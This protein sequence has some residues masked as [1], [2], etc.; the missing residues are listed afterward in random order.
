MVEGE[1]LLQLSYLKDYWEKD[2][3]M[4]EEIVRLINKISKQDLLQE[5]LNTHQISMFGCE[6]I[7]RALFVLVKELGLSQPYLEAYE[8]TDGE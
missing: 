1:L 7:K 6:D 8:H 4:R 5:G 3:L 2:V